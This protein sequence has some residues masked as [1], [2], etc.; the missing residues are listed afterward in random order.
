[1]SSVFAFA[2]DA[3]TEY[4]QLVDEL[5]DVQQDGVTPDELPQ[6]ASI[7]GG[8]RHLQPAVEEGAATLRGIAQLAR[9][10]VTRFPLPPMRRE[11]AALRVYGAQAAGADNIIAFP[12]NKNAPS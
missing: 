1:M 2:D 8:F 9:V 5:E 3:A 4:A 6:L 11:I 10:G 12:S 7:A